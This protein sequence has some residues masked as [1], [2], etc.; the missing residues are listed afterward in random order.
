[1]LTVVAA[2][3]VRDALVLAAHRT[4]GPAGW[5]FPGGKCEPGEGEQDAVHR[6]IAEELGIDVEVG[7]FVAA[8]ASATIELRLYRARL[9]G[10]EP[11]RSTDHDELR[12]VRADELFGLTWLPLDRPLLPAVA[13]LLREPDGNET[14][15]ER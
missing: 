5:E 4:G 12:W 6:E 1:M 7:V 10:S 2:A 3:I 8:S 11:S 14:P 15:V 13:A 9:T